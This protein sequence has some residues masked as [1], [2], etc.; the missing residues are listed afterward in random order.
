MI[1]AKKRWKSSSGMLRKKEINS[2]KKFIFNSKGNKK[3]LFFPFK[4][5]LFK[6]QQTNGENCVLW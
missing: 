4:K 3:S 2:A 1:E 6:L 5:K